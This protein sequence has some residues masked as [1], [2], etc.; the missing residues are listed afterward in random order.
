MIDVQTHYLHRIDA[1]ARAR[2]WYGLRLTRSL[3]GEPM[4]IRSWGRIGGR[5]ARHA[6][7]TH[8]S[9]ASAEASLAAWRRAKLR[10][11][12]APASGTA[13]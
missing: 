10:R 7:E 12:Y 4:L 5:G 1:P 6:V 8:P 2:R 3:F 11:G 9:A 13:S